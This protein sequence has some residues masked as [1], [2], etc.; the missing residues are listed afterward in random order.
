MSLCLSVGQNSKSGKIK[1]VSMDWDDF[2]KNLQEPIKT[3]ETI[4]E[5]LKMHPDEQIKIKDQ[6]YFILGSHTEN[7]RGNKYLRDRCGL[8][9]DI[10]HLT[11]PDLVTLL[12][13]LENS[14]LTYALYSTH[15]HTPEYPRIRVIFPVNRIMEPGE[16]EPVS[17]AVANKLRFI[18]WCDHTGFQAAR[19]MFWPSVARN[20]QYVFRH[21]S[22]HKVDVDKMLMSLGD[23]RNPM[24]WPRTEKEVAK[25]IKGDETPHPIKDKQENPTEK[26]GVIGAFCRAFSVIDVIEN[27]LTGVYIPGTEGRY[28]YAKST[29]SNGAIVYDDGLYLFSHHESDPGFNK[30]LNA[31]DLLRLHRYPNLSVQRLMDKVSNLSAVKAEL[32]PAIDFDVLPDADDIDTIPKKK[33]GDVARELAEKYIFVL[34]QDAFIE[35]KTSSII[36]PGAL[37]RA[38]GFRFNKKANVSRELGKAGIRQVDNLSWH[39]GEGKIFHDSRGRSLVNTYTPPNIK[40]VKGDIHEWWYLINYLMPGRKEREHLLDWMAFNVQNPGRKCNHQ[41]IFGGRMGIGKDSIF[42]PMIAAIGPHNTSQPQADSLLSSFNEWLDKSRLVVVQELR[43]FNKATLENSL[44]PYAAA[45]PA[46]IRINCKGVRTFEIANVLSIIMLTN[47]R[48]AIA[49]HTDDR[50]YFCYWS[51]SE[52]LS[53][54]FYT[55][56]HN[57]LKNG[58]INSCVYYLLHRD[59]SYFNPG[60]KPPVT[61]YK[62][63]LI[64]TG[65]PE[66]IQ[67]LREMIVDGQG[68]FKNDIV[69]IAEIKD[70][71]I[72][73][74]VSRTNPS[75]IG[76]AMER[77]KEIGCGFFKCRVEGGGERRTVWIIRNPQKYLAKTNKELYKIWSGLP[78]EMIH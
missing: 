53:E 74:G 35:I 66:Y 46:T 8:A 77:L 39:P 57:W 17:R 4:Q 43:N 42:L 61:V 1:Q 25:I 6:G 28:T 64:H 73:N 26:A 41:V 65:L 15:K 7:K 56:Y 71:M 69:S 40:P 19:V 51:D 29:T 36:K 78:S 58:G 16:Y 50:R 14:G 60:A 67:D 11:G 62:Q 70:E 45:P 12:N 10:D 23:W 63:E 24:H 59:I 49:L 47:Y 72:R 34:E 37:E 21:S 33:L 31:F 44:K 27:F 9:M 54:S 20:G 68:V 30:L 32:D 52:P 5:Y 22:G 13:N 75:A 76:K 3:G 2:L 48:D 55:N 38:Y 18:Q